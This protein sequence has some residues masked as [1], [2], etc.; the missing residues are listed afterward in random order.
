MGEI[1]LFQVLTLKKEDIVES[2]RNHKG[3]TTGLATT[4][5]SSISFKYCQIYDRLKHN[6]LSTSQLCDKSYE[7]VFDKKT[8]SSY[9]RI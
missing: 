2:G 6:L 4:G 7:V 8:C 5:N 3:K 1:H 9:Q